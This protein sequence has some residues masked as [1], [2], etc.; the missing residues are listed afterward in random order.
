M[1]KG[2]VVDVEAGSIDPVGENLADARELI[3]YGDRDLVA[4]YGFSGKGDFAGGCKSSDVVLN[5]V[6]GNEFAVG[7][8][9]DKKAELHRWSF[10]LGLGDS[11]ED[12]D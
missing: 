5:S 1:S 10:G 11:P 3:D 6:A 9:G 2:L 4:V 8:E 7:L 12:S